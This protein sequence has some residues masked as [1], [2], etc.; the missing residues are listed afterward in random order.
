MVEQAARC[1]D[2]DVHTAPQRVTLRA[3]GDS[4]EDRDGLQTHGSAVVAE[5]PV[6]LERQLACRHEDETAWRARAGS[7]L[8][9]YEQAVDHRQA[10]GRGL[11]GTCLR[12]REQVFAVED[13]RDRLRLDRG[14]LGVTQAS[15]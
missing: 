15:Q 10:K 6:Y 14:R 2:H 12:A 1:R 13:D 5:R 8:S 4:A 7:A 3:E 11:S 9:A